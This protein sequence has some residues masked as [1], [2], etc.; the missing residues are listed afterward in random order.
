MHLY[1]TLL[2]QDPLHRNAQEGLLL[3]AAGAADP[4]GLEVAWARLRTTWEGEVPDDLR[5]LH[6]RLQREIAGARRAGR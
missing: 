1:T 4:S 5:E 3:A 6:D 2:D